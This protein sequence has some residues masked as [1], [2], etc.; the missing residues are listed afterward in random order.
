MP[1]ANMPINLKFTER[2]FLF[3][4]SCT[5]RNLQHVEILQKRLNKPDAE[6]SVE[7]FDDLMCAFKLYA[8]KTD[9]Q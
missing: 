1:D 6:A 5:T 8:K 4:P 7:Q 3:R 2:F 9:W